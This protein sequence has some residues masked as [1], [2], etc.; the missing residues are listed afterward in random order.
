VA[1]VFLASLVTALAT[2]LG[3]VPFVFAKHMRRWWIGL[4][5]AAA[6]GVMLTASFGMLNQAVSEHGALGRT[7]VG[8]GIGLALVVASHSWLTGL[9]REGEPLVIGALK[10]A[11]AREALLIVGVMTAHSFSEGVAV[12]V[13]HGGDGFL[14]PVLT[15]S[16]ALHN[17]PEG[18]AIS[19]VLVPRGV[20]VLKSAGWSIFS[21]LPQPLAAVPAF[22]FV[23]IFEP[24]LP[25]GMGFAAG[26]MI[27]VVVGELLPDALAE[28]RSQTVAIVVTLSCGVMLAVQALLAG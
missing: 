6:A 22:V 15:A 12:G 28:C 18:L 25:V 8:I 9:R 13:A 2:G 21:S 11:D 5:N 4:A 20:S 14:G 3:A 27:W 7:L 19:L 1:S 17:I 23:R 26:A 16:I 10:G 24:V